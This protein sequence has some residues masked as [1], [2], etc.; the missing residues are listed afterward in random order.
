MLL[1]LG[2]LAARQ[3]IPALVLIGFVPL[4]TRTIWSLV[5]PPARLALKRIGVLEISYSLTF[6]LF[7]WLAFHRI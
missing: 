6:L 4:W 1:L 3:A 2:L 5:R 7:G